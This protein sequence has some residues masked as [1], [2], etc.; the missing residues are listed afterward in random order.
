MLIHLAISTTFV[1]LVGLE[2][3]FCHLLMAFCLGWR[4]WE[5]DVLLEKREMGR[6]AFEA[7]TPKRLT[8]E[9]F[10]VGTLPEPLWTRLKAEYKK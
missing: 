7:D 2:S 8:E 1:I 10:N 3:S 4:F 6:K 9:G 5:V